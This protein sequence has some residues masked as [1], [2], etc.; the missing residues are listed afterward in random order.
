[1]KIPGRLVGIGAAAVLVGGVTVAVTTTAPRRPRKACSRRAGRPRRRPT[2]CPRSAPPTPSTATPAPGG[3][4]PK[5]SD[6][7]WIRVDLGATATITHVNLNWE[8]AYGKAYQIQTSADGNAWTTIYTTTDRQR[9][10]RRPHRALAAPVGTCGCTAPR[11]A[12][13]RLLAVRVQGLRH[14]RHHPV[15]SVSASASKSPTASPSPSKAPAAA[16]AR[17]PAP[18]RTSPTREEGHRDAAGVQRG[19]LLAGLEGAVQVHRGHRRRPRLHRRAS[20]ASARAPA[21][22]STWSSCYTDRKPGQRARQVPAGPA[23]ASNGSDSHAGLDPNFTKD[24]K[25][26]AEDTG[27]PAGPERRARPGLLQPGG[28]AGARPTACARSASSPTT[29][30]SSCTAPA[31]T[32][33]AS[34]ASASAR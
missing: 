8:A 18:A 31:T 15:A 22:C 13:V 5:A 1:M 7:Q 9:R 2:S 28:A 20:S 33:S 6:P 10:H 3:P 11:A 16:R 24:W 27:V 34:A 14:R 32:P 29:T 19:E 12:P 26:A 17:A 4:A 25:T 23:Q 30:P 21:T